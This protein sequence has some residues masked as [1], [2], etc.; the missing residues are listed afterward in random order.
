MRE[1][2]VEMSTIED[3]Y[4][5]PDGERA[6]LIDGVLYMMATPTRKHQ[7]IVF[8]T[9]YAISKYVKEHDGTCE[10]DI[11]PFGVYLFDDDSTYL[12]PDV[13][14]ICDKKRLDN[15]GCHGAPDLVLEVSS[16][17][18]RSRDCLLKHRKYEAAGVREYWIIDQDSEVIDVYRF[19]KE[20]VDRYSFQDQVPTDICEG[21]SI[22]FSVMNLE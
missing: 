14:V 19:E 8:E 10:V 12:E 17:S 16:P 15:K 18:T 5:L 1:A 3:V 13:I 22:D 20:C 4:A 11:A 21:L 2:L 9:A 6:E 7:R